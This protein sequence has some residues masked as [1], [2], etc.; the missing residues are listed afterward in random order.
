MLKTV[1]V[2]IPAYNVEK[3]LS[4]AIT[5][6]LDQTYSLTEVIVVNDGS[7]DQTATIAENY[8]SAD[9]RVR[10]FN[11]ENQGLS[12]ARNSGIRLA[13]GDIIAFLDADD[14][15]HPRYL[16]KMV[17]RLRK[18]E[19]LGISFSRIQYADEQGK[20]L[21][22]YTRGHVKNIRPQDFYYMNPLSCGSNIVIKKR[23]LVDIGLFDRCL[24]SYEDLD[25][26]YR[27]ASHPYFNISGVK[28]HLVY[29]RI[30]QGLSYDTLQ[31]I[32]AWNQ[33]MQKV[34]ARVP[35]EYCRHYLPGLLAQSLF[36]ARNS[37]RLGLSP[38]ISRNYLFFCLKRPRSLL[39][40]AF[41]YPIMVFFSFP[42]AFFDTLLP[43]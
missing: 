33:V 31:M 4:T 16:E 27:A 3:Y 34:K 6:A 10:L 15:W 37:K 17:F 36:F 29:Y 25:F 35:G 38:T 9:S 14:W 43:V 24:K 42:K 28:D 2:I 39:Q 18:D 26:L 5:S 12:G 32:T 7:V 8:Q 13:A 1:S 30:R 20:L 21:P 19:R 22:L 40:L 11:Q 23:F 41:R